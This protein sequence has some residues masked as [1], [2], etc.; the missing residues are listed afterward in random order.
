MGRREWTNV[1]ARC[2]QIKTAMF[3]ALTLTARHDLVSAPIA[4]SRIL[5]NVKLAHMPFQASVANKVWSCKVPCSRVKRG[6]G[7]SDSKKC[8]ESKI[9]TYT[10]GSLRRALLSGASK[11]K[12]CACTASKT[13]GTE[14]LNPTPIPNHRPPDCRDSKGTCHDHHRGDPYPATHIPCRAGSHHRSCSQQNLAILPGLGGR[15]TCISGKHH[16]GLAF[17]TFG[18]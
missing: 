4:P 11:P 16:V 13:S 18:I 2:A 5:V 3:A 14:C 7:N 12:A 17:S 10:K 9:K 6:P 8:V 15:R 1:L